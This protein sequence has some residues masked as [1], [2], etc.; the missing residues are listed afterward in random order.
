MHEGKYGEM[1]DWFHAMEGAALLGVT[2]WQWIGIPEPLEVPLCAKAWAFARATCKYWA[3][4]I[5]TPVNEDE[6]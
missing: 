4:K 1:P 5:N 3:A 6:D 2:I